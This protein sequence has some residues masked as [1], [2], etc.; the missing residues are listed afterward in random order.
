MS[1][2][3]LTSTWR[4][5]DKR[6]T[7]SGMHPTS[8]TCRLPV[9]RSLNSS[10]SRRKF[11]EDGGHQL[12][13]TK[14]AAPLPPAYTQ[15]RGSSATNNASRLATA[16]FEPSRSVSVVGGIVRSTAQYTPSASQPTRAV[17]EAVRYGSSSQVWTD[18]NRPRRSRLVLSSEWSCLG[19]LAY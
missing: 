4:K 2:T 9:P 8:Y 1:I 13:L 10:E 14:E 16:L 12:R 3:V 5:H 19:A 6:D 15:P 17:G 11:E 18:G 7:P